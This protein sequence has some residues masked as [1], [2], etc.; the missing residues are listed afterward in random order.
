MAVTLCV[1]A[2]QAQVTVGDDLKFQAN[3]SLGYNYSGSFGNQDLSGHGQGLVAEMDAAGYYFHPNFLSFQLRPYYNRNQT[4]STSQV[5]NNSSGIG[6]SVGLFAGSRFPG[7]ISYGKDFSSNSQFQLAGIPTVST[8]GS[9][10]NFGINWSTLVPNLPQ[11]TAN[12]SSASSNSSFLDFGDTK[13]SSKIFNINSTYLL[14]GFNLQAGLSRYS[15][16]FETPAY[17]IYQSRSADS[18]GT[19]YNASA[20]HAL[21]LRGSFGLSWS[22][23][24]MDSGIGTEYG[25]TTYNATNSFAPFRNFSIYQNA[26]YLTNL[27]GSL[28]QSINGAVTSE[29]QFDSHSK[30]FFYNTGA[31][32]YLGKGISVG[33]YYNH[34]YQ[35]LDGAHYTDSQYGGNINFNHASRFFGFLS[36]SVGASDTANA[37]GNN[38]AGLNA[39]VSANKRFGRWETS[40]DFT[41]AQ[42]VMTIGSVTTTSNYSYGADVRRKVNREFA[43]GGSYRASRSGLVVVDGNGNTANSFSG[44]LQWRK[45]NFGGSYSK[46]DGT[47]ILNNSGTLTPT[48]EGPI[49]T[50]DLLLFN[51]RS[52]T[53]TASATLF[54]RLSLG[55][56]Y[57]RFNSGTLS[58]LT[59]VN[60]DGDRFSATMRYGLRKFQVNGGFSH[61]T[62][63]VSTIPGGPRDISSYYFGI[64][65]WF[66]IF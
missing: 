3:G 24:N 19:T 14:E 30:G 10:Q 28:L 35:N 62:L 7:S 18:S 59:G 56:G 47:A 25:T 13:S 45:Y 5:I 42:N 53:A 44:I 16:S 17:L 63:S 8:N 65:R 2:A 36:L 34:R 4:N 15:G 26:S 6:A 29:T 38:G 32:Y 50:K 46:S 12:F 22:H 58:Q 48:P 40:A 55:G 61:T 51:A 60:T 64:S 9:G 27:Y 57:S 33:G 66:N 49:I 54:R 20:G 39:V 21:P 52:Y 41:Y 37:I 43:F 31:S 11:V 23:S 1:G